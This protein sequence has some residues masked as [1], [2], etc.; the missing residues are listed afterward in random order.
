MVEGIRKQILALMIVLGIFLGIIVVGTSSYIMFNEIEGNPISNTIFKDLSKFGTMPI[1][2]MS[3][4]ASNNESYFIDSNL[5]NMPLISSSQAREAAYEFLQSIFNENQLESVSVQWQHLVGD[6]PTWVIAI[7]GYYIVTLLFVSAITGELIGWN[8][9]SLS[10]DPPE[11]Y[12]ENGSYISASVAEECVFD[13][14]ALH[15]YSIPDGARY[16]GVNEYPSDLN[17]YYAIFR[18]YEGQFPVGL[19]PHDSSINPDYSSEGIILRIDKRTGFITQFGYRW[20]KIDP[21]PP[22]GILPEWEAG[23]IAGAFYEPENISLIDAQILIAPV[24]GLESSDGSPQIH[25]IWHLAI[26]RDSRLVYVYIDAYTGEVLD[27]QRT[28]GNAPAIIN[29]N[30]SPT[31]FPVVITSLSIGVTVAVSSSY[32]IRKRY[33]F[34][35]GEV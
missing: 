34:D 4:M 14:L 24:L 30:D 35:S 21:P 26:N 29:T 3:G 17:N 23:R 22:I 31:L 32:M 18:H 19:Y 5:W 15:N 7:E 13:F 27:E 28:N 6:N 33:L 2:D 1:I 16:L 12:Y 8:L 10:L 11:S 9:S 25:L 20:T